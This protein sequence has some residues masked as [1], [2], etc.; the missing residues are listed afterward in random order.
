LGVSEPTLRVLVGFVGLLTK[1]GVDVLELSKVNDVPLGVFAVY[2]LV[3]FFTQSGEFCLLCFFK[4]FINPLL[5]LF[6]VK[7]MRLLKVIVHNLP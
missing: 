2:N 6:K 5:V 4:I 3:V 7:F 1:K